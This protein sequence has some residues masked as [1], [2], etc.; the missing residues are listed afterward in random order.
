M[1]EPKRLIV[2]GFRVTDEE[3]EALRFLAKRD[4]RTVSDYIRLTVFDF[5]MTNGNGWREWLEEKAS[6]DE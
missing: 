4:R 6:E 5:A 1:P 3:R 2:M